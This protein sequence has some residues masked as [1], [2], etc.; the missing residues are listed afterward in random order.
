MN[1]SPVIT[2]RTWH[3]IPLR[4]MK[5]TWYPGSAWPLTHTGASRTAW[6]ISWTVWIR[7]YREDK[8][9]SN[10]ALSIDWTSFQMSFKQKRNRRYLLCWNSLI[11]EAPNLPGLQARTVSH[12][13][14]QKSFWLFRTT[15]RHPA[16]AGRTSNQKMAIFSKWS[17]INIAFVY[18]KRP[19]RLLGADT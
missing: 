19:E 6:A 13:G 11:L 15:P 9:R 17:S 8:G 14:W 3:H 10:K 5:A 1:I 16:T 4:S 7:S 18:H 12:G 2:I